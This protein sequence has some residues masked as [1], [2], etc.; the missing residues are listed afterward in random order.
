MKAIGVGGYWFWVVVV[1][2]MVLGVLEVGALDDPLC[3]ELTVGTEDYEVAG[4]GDL[5]VEKKVPGFINAIIFLMGFVAVGMVVFGGVRY[6][7]SQGDPAKVKNAK[8]TIMYAVV[9]LIVTILA[10][11]IVNFILQGV[12]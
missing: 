5:G 3:N 11:A 2:L 9:G 12:W 10:Y 1:G 6:A 7:I 4:C 8:D